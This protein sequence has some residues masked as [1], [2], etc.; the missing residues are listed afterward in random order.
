MWKK[1]WFRKN[2][3][4]W[5]CASNWDKRISRM[6]A[7]A[8]VI[9]IA[10]WTIVSLIWLKIL[11]LQKINSCMK[12]LLLLQLRF[13]QHNTNL[14]M[15]SELNQTSSLNHSRFHTLPPNLFN[16]KGSHGSSSITG[17]AY[18]F[19]EEN[20]N[21]FSDFYIEHFAEDSKELLQNV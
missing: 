6:G 18:E 14:E 2:H 16:W 4:L 12:P 5:I 3:H 9:C 21:L 7:R 15:G 19:I 11:N 20:S 17:S 10:I 8:V 1:L 13:W